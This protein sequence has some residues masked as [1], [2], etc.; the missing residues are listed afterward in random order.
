MPGQTE[1]V[2]TWDPVARE[3]R[4][5]TVP[6]TAGP[7]HRARPARPARRTGAPVNYAGLSS[8]SPLP[9]MSDTAYAPCDGFADMRT[10][11]KPA[12]MQTHRAPTVLPA[13]NAGDVAERARW[14]DLH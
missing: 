1:T 14:I 4:T 10:W 2:R 13:G 8:G 6:V 9:P 7:V 5:A 12:T 11:V 3:W